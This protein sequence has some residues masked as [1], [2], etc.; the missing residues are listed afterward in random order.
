ME[1]SQTV[2]HEVE[3]ETGENQK[4]DSR[5]E[6]SEENHSKDL[7]K[8]LSTS[9][10][11]E[12]HEFLTQEDHLENRIGNCLPEV[13]TLIDKS[14]LCNQYGP[15]AGNNQ[16]RWRKHR[17]FFRQTFPL[18]LC[19]QIHTGGKTLQVHAVWEVLQQP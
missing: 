8:K 18:P 19:Q 15:H 5:S 14:E 11:A 2:Q 10:C 17:T 4:S 7:E 6:A 3:K 13:T 16:Y 9:R 12:I 1:A